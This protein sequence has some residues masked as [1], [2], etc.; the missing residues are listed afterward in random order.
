MAHVAN[1]DE[2]PEAKRKIVADGGLKSLTT[3]I[4]HGD[5]TISFHAINAIAAIA[6]EK[7]HQTVRSR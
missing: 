6:T 4:L 7:E 1:S 3:L 5:P 2:D